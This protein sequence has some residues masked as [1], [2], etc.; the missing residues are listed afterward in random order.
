LRLNFAEAR[1]S[2]NVFQDDANV[3]VSAVLDADVEA[4]SSQYEERSIALTVTSAFAP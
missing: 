1:P 2:M 3:V 4:A